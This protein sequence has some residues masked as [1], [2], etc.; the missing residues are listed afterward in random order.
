M[1]SGKPP[2]PPGPRSGANAR[3]GPQTA[4]PLRGMKQKK[5]RWTDEQIAALGELAARWG[6]T[7]SAAAARAVEEAL[8]RSK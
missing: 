7:Q 5:L 3:S 8:A 6:V 1:A 2:K 4:E